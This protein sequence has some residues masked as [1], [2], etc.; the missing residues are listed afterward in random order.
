MLNNL[1]LD[2]GWGMLGASR[3]GFAVAEP[4]VLMSKSELLKVQVLIVHVQMSNHVQS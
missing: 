1:S 3:L 4:Q 2:G